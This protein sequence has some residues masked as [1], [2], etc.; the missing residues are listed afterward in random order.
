M[1]FSRTAAIA[2]FASFFAFDLPAA[3]Q[4]VA[5]GSHQ[6]LQSDLSGLVEAG[7]AFGGSLAAGDFDGD[8][9]DDLAIGVPTEDVGSAVDAGAMVVVYGTAAGLNAPG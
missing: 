1:A 4:L 2:L 7:D 6:I 5:T 3:A 9:Y 8:G